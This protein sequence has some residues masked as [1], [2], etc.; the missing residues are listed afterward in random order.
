VV[1]GVCIVIWLR[2][3][4]VD[5]S[6]CSLIPWDGATRGWGKL[7]QCGQSGVE[8]G[9]YLRV[10]FKQ[11]E[12]ASRGAVAQAWNTYVRRYVAGSACPTAKEVV[13]FD[14]DRDSGAGILFPQRPPGWDA[15]MRE[16]PQWRLLDA[17]NQ[18]MTEQVC[19]FPVEDSRRPAGWAGWFR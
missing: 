16:E 9:Y 6:H 17:S 18:P 4:D 14:K 19:F 10:A 13:F 11:D 1:V 5:Q 12:S 3:R 2:S 8:T 15:V 7:G